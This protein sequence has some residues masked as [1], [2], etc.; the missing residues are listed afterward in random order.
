MS[1][2]S[3]SFQS[4]PTPTETITPSWCP[5][6]E[7]KIF[8]IVSR[9]LR[10][11]AIRIASIVASEPE[12]VKRH[13]GRPKRRASSSATTIPS[14]V[15]AAKCVPSRARSEIASTIAGCAWPMT[16]EP[17]PLWKSQSSRPST[18]QTRAPWPRSR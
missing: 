3:T 15:G 13:L 12:F 2:G 6:Y 17:K 11:R 16:I 10:P 7:P 1:S 18:S 4:T 14:S 8:M 9:P 5:W